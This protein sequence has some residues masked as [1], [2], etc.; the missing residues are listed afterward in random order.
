MRAITPALLAAVVAFG[1]AASPADAAKKKKRVYSAPPSRA[2]VY[3]AP[4]RTVI[5][6]NGVTRIV[7]NRRSYLDPGTEVSVG[8]GSY[9]D[10]VLPPGGDPGR[11]NWFMGGP[12]YR[13]AGSW[14]LPSAFDL[15]GFNPNTPF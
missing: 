10:Y 8:E 5:R 2:A 6:I 1:L 3:P 13:G 4:D 11:S 7:V 15:P 9:R 12:D 14:P